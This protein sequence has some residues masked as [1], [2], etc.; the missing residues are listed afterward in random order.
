MRVL[1]A[2]AA[3]ING[4]AT[5]LTLH[6]A[7][8]HHLLAATRT[9]GHAAGAAEV[10]TSLHGLAVLGW[11]SPGWVEAMFEAAESVEPGAWLPEEAAMLAWSVAVL[12]VRA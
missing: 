1:Q 4:F 9:N 2:V 6:P 5:S 3:I 8:L 10:A 11:D 7:L 12:E